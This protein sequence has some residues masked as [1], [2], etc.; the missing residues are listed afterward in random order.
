MAE[1]R[2]EPQVRRRC[3]DRTQAARP[4]GRACRARYAMQPACSAGEGRGGS[5]ILNVPPLGTPW[6]LAAVAARALRVAERQP[7]LEREIRAQKVG[8]VGAVGTND[9]PHLVFAQTQ[10][11]EQE[12]ARSIAQHLMQRLPR[13]LRLERCVEERLDPRRIKVFRPAISRTAHRPDAPRRLA[14]PRRRVAE[15]GDVAGDRAAL[16]RRA[17]ARELRVP[18][19]HRRRRDLGEPVIR[20]PPAVH[21]MWRRRFHRARPAKVRPRAASRQRRRRAKARP[22]TAQSARTGPRVRPRL[23]RRRTALGPGSPRSGEGKRKMHLRP[24]TMLSQQP[25]VSKSGVSEVIEPPSAQWL[26]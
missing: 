16:G 9:H 8:E 15:H 14:R 10:I 17:I 13:R 18:R 2:R 1:R 7:H 21:A 6:R 5:R 20:R 4:A 24:A 11:V 26:P 19:P 25:G 3:A 23:R 12:I 22:S